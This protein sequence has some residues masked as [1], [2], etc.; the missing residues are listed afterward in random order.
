[1]LM[2]YYGKKQIQKNL[3]DFERLADYCIFILK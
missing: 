1:M 3:Q 2:K